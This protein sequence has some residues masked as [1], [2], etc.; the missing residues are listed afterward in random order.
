MKASNRLFFE[1]KLYGRAGSARYQRWLE[2]QYE[3]QG[4]RD[5]KW[6]PS[7]ERGSSA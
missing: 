5:N 7:E 3:E 2:V 1:T 6:S 4:R